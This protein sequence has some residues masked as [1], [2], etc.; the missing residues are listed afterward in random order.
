MKLAI[1]E[2]ERLGV[3]RQR[4]EGVGVGARDDGLRRQR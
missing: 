4:Q 2:G 1:A 3:F